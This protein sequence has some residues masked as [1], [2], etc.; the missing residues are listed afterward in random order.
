MTADP[1]TT[2]QSQSAALGAGPM[3]DVAS[4]NVEPRAAPVLTSDGQQN[5]VTT[6]NNQ[7]VMETRNQLESHPASG[8]VPQP[9]KSRQTSE[10]V[11]LLK[12]KIDRL[13]AEN[14]RLKKDLEEA[15]RQRM[16]RDAEVESLRGY[17]MAVNDSDGSDAV[18]LLE[19]INNSTLTLA[20]ALA[21]DWPFPERKGPRPDTKELPILRQAL[22]QCEPS[23]PQ[24]PLLL[25]IAFQSCILQQATWIVHKAWYRQEKQITRYVQRLERKLK[26]SESQPTF[27]R[28]R[29]LTYQII[30][31]DFTKDQKKFSDNVCEATIQHIRH[32]ANLI[33]GSPLQ[34][35]ES[36]KMEKQVWEGMQDITSLSIQLAVMLQTRILS[37]NYHVWCPIDEKYVKDDME[38]PYS[39]RAPPE[40][41]TISAVVSLGLW[42]D[43]KLGRQNVDGMSET[44]CKIHL[45]PH[46]VMKKE[47]GDLLSEQHTSSKAMSASDDSASTDITKG[48][49]STEVT[50]SY[51]LGRIFIAAWQWLVGSISRASRG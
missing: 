46:V 35:K 31:S 14:D 4:T 30:L 32:L 49:K 22:V 7:D 25:Q 10:D 48:S 15:T 40:G 39:E 24:A 50:N 11:H 27:S 45:R 21:L 9:D 16:I 17:A 18:T 36:K 38:S 6:K 42:R 13:K 44:L 37:A 2:T 28:W 43:E 20:A 51:F 47:L 41:D 29:A 33:G 23:N 8:S 1:P 26:S 19:S 5:T 34:S 3:P 12:K